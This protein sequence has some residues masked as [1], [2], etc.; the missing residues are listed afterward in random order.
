M[1]EQELNL[2]VMLIGIPILILITIYYYSNPQYSQC[3][4]C[5]KQISHTKQNRYWQK[6]DGKNHAICGGCYKK[7]NSVTVTNQSF[8]LVRQARVTHDVAHETKAWSSGNVDLMVVALLTEKSPIDRH[9]LFQNIVEITYKDR[10]NSRSRDLCI[11]YAEMHLAEFK[12]LSTHLI[13]QLG[14]LP[15]VTSFQYLA[16]IYTE[17]NRFRKAIEVCNQALDHGLDDGTKSGFEGRIKRIKS[18]ENKASLV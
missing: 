9:F 13:V 10:K 8:N 17:D 16:T 3:H 4:I 14:S 18:K 7:R 2:I 15:R 12:D 5:G 1:T 11:E 6:V